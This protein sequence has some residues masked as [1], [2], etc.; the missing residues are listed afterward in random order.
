MSRRSMAWRVVVSMIAIEVTA[1]AVGACASSEESTPEAD[2]G[3]PEVGSPNEPDASVEA[4]PVEAAARTCSDQNFCHTELPPSETLRDVWGDGT[5]VW[6]VSEQGDVLRW[7]GSAWSV[8]SSKLGVLYAIWG[9]GPTDIWLGGAKG[10]YHGTGASSASVVFEPVT[11][12]GN[13]EVAI[14]SIWGSSATDIVAAGGDLD[15]DDMLPRSRVLRWDGTSW[16][17]DPI[18]AEP[19]AFTRVWGGAPGETWLGGDDGNDFSQ[20]LGVFRRTT[21]AGDFD[22]IVV[23]AHRDED[24]P[25]QGLPGTFHGGGVGADGRIVIVGRALSYAQAYWYGTKGDGGALEWTC[26]SRVLDDEPLR[27]IWSLPGSNATWAAGDYGRLRSLN[28]SLWTQA[29]LMLGD[30]PII[31]PLYGMWGTKADDFWIV[32]KDTAIHRTPR[33]P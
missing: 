28:G 22:P 14:R 11:A 8:H 3:R 25:M 19:F 23:D 18:S 20:T 10:L 13:D 17:L 7:D 33:A 4:A 9:S 26:D 24:G 1:I 12:P 30:L 21:S 5:I 15:P 6:S 31:E 32:G 29:A 16:E 2:A 27:S